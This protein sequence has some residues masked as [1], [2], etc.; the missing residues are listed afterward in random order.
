MS[1]TGTEIDG[2]VGFS[3]AA[4]TF[5]Y[6]PNNRAVSG[7]YDFIGVAEHELSHA[8]GRISD[9][10]SALTVLD[11]FR[12]AS[13]HHLQTGSGSAYFSVNGGV[14]NLNNYSTSSD[15]GDWAASAG[16][17][18]NNAFSSSGV[19]NLFTPVDVTQLD[20]LG[21]TTAT[22]IASAA[23]DQAAAQ[24]ALGAAAASGLVGLQGV[25]HP[26][27]VSAAFLA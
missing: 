3:S 14:T 10:P 27:P 16:H 17:D 23:T 15:L 20:V 19:A 12:Y 7:L 9:V 24:G 26:D 2:V 8:L 25:P 4:N 13:A 18:A 22:G 6:D 5:T 21:F 1:A 11:L